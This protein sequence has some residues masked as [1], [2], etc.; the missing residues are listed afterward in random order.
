[1]TVFAFLLVTMLGLTGCKTAAERA[2]E[3]FQSA[4]TLAEE[5]DYDRAVV[6]LR[7]VFQLDASHQEA[8]RL[9]AEIMLEE[10]G[11]RQAAYSHYLR[12]A[13]QYPE[14]LDARIALARIAFSATDWEELERHGA[15]AEALAPEDPRVV[16][17]AVARGYRAALISDDL[18][19]AEDHA[20]RA[21]SLLE[22]DPDD[23]ILRN[24]VIDQL[25]RNGELET[26]LEDIDHLLEL[27]PANPL[28]NQQRLNVL[29]QLGD[30]QEI[31]AHLRNMIERFPENA[32]YKAALL[33]FHL[34]RDDLDKA[35]N[36]LRD[37]A[38]A[39][40]NDPV[41]KVDLIRFLSEY[42]SIAAAKAE[43]AEM[44]DGVDDPLPFL[45][46]DA[47]LDFAS[48]QREDALATLE[49][50]VDA[51]AD[52]PRILEAR[53]ALAR[54]LLD[55]GND[56]GA[57]SEVEEVLSEDPEQPEALK[58]R[59]RWLIQSDQTDAAIAALRTALDRSPD[60]AQA[61]TL[62][63]DAYT[64]SGRPEL[65]REF[66]S[67]AVEASGNAPEETVRYARVLMADESYLPAEDLLITS[68][69]LN[70]DHPDL[71]VT[72]GRVY[73]EMQDF[74]R[75]QQ[76]AD[77]LRRLD[78]AA[79]RSAANA[80]EAERINRQSGRDEAIAYLEDIASSAGTDFA[81]RIALLRARLAAG[82]AAAA[83]Q[84]AREMA[85]ENPESDDL[86][87]ILATTE[88]LD[89]NLDTAEGIYRDLLAEDPRRA[90][91]WLDLSR[92]QQRKG[93]RDAAKAVV[94]EGLEHMP[95]DPSLLWA[96]ASF[97]E[98]DGDFDGAIEIYEGLYAM[99]SDALVVANNLAS[100]L[101]T[102]RDDEESLERAWT[103]ARR[104]RDTD[105]PAVQD[106][107]GWILQRRGS[108]E[109]ALPYLEAAAAG[110][111]DDPLVNYHLGQT[112]LSLERMDEALERFR[113]AVQ[114]AGPG[115]TRPQIEAARAQISALLD[116]QKTGEAAE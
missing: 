31:E 23:Q 97:L 4:I 30:M 47:G 111:P 84:L 104:F 85:A 108:S 41:R 101:S 7:N 94:A 13:E 3:H 39:A 95:S 75:A 22:E 62:M 49:R 45:M 27:D 67:L 26:A 33:R 37:L 42:R 78:T 63:A 46:I 58:M 103:V 34:S 61:M 15:S 14:D 73:L 92:L 76:V 52:S 66:L 71:L 70:A 11:N 20:Q 107:Y 50:A 6:S 1:M 19:A 29:A 79:T 102:Y 60:D 81:A 89:G 68:L 9:M 88:A 18:P 90:R 100:L 116:A 72:L 64:R 65:A 115:D 109:E 38:D 91:I 69:R 57:R 105:I 86:R 5:G 24:I 96:Q 51:H 12:L 10:R 87:F 112:Y 99:N 55:M 40:E 110:L 83:L 8:R 77:T 80:I 48:G 21:R 25:L 98:Q 56:V 16:P 53:V 17:L 93:E 106:T 113:R 32:D 82:D 2:E 43:I 36:F 28:Y 54:M 59:A 44:L 114:V 35:E 74:G